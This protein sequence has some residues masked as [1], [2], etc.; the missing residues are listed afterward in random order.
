MPVPPDDWLCRFLHADDWDDQE[1]VLPTAFESMRIRPEHRNELSLFHVQ[2]VV[3]LGDSLSDLCFDYLDGAG[4]LHLRSRDF[5]EAE[6]K[7]STVFEPTVEW[8]PERTEPA[9]RKWE[10][11]HAQVESAR[12]SDGFPLDYRIELT[13]RCDVVREPD[14][15][16]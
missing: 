5:M 10:S 7:T 13:T 2:R 6:S 3:D 12:P 1:G 16:T 8:R 14:E 9:W 15:S 4:E 11:A